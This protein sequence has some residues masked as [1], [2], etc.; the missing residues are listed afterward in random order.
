MLAAILQAA[1][2]RT[3]LYTSPHMERIEERFVIDGAACSQEEFVELTRSVEP[4]FRELDAA[5]VTTGLREP[6]FFE[7][8]TAMAFQHFVQ[9]QVDIAVLEVGLGGRLDST[10]ICQPVVSVITSISFDHTRQL[11]NTLAAIAGEKAG[12]IKPGIPA[13]S[14]VTNLEPR[15]VIRR[16]ASLAGAP[17]YERDVDFSAEVVSSDGSLLAGPVINYGDTLQGEAWRLDDVAVN[18]LGKHQADNA[19]LAIATSRALRAQSWRLPDQAIRS[20]LAK[21]QC[22]ARIEIV[23]RNPTVIVDTA[24]NVASIEALCQTLRQAPQSRRVLIFAA[25]RDKDAAGI[26][27]RLLPEFD[28]IVLTR[29]VKNPRARA[30]AELREMARHE[31]ARLEPSVAPRLHESPDPET[32]WQLAQELAGDDS[33]LCITGSFFLAAELRSTASQSSATGERGT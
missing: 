14:G 5:A 11:G 2:Y 31:A 19:A 7:I 12:I 18:L 16:A 29:F 22:P 26:L 23:R 4:A 1:G 8:T 13:I 33:L 24:H 25:S 3:G 10:N 9:R 6:T 17:L 28:E 20:G 21:V 27:K 32:A 30:P 15:D